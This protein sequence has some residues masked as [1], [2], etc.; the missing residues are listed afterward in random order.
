MLLLL[1]VGVGD[2]FALGGVGRGDG[3]GVGFGV[4]VAVGL[5]A[6]FV[7]CFVTVTLPFFVL[8]IF[9]LLMPNALRSLA[10]LRVTLPSFRALSS[11]FCFCLAVSFLAMG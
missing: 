3:A 4:G 9:L 6:F 5:L 11:L 10:S 2:G 7:A 8:V 1:R